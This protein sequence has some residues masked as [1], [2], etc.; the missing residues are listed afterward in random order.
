MSRWAARFRR[1]RDRCFRAGESLARVMVAPSGKIPPDQ[2]TTALL[3][4]IYL[5]LM[6]L[7]TFIRAL[8]L[9]STGS[10]VWLPLLVASLAFFFAYGISRTRHY[11]AAFA[12]AT[13]VPLAPPFAF[14]LSRQPMIDPAT[15]L[16][17]LSIPLIMATLL[18]KM[19][20]TAIVGV[21]YLVFIIWLIASDLIGVNA[22]VTAISF[23]FIITFFATVISII[24]RSSQKRLERQLAELRQAQEA[25][26]LSE[27]KFA[28]AFR[29]S[30]NA[31]VISRIED[32]TIIEANDTFSRLTGYRRDEVIGKKSSELGLWV[33]PEKRAEIVRLMKEQGSVHQRECLIRMK[34]GEVRVWLFSAEIINIEGE[35]CMLSVT[36]DITERK[37]ME[38]DLR[39]SDTALRSI[40]E[41]VFAM[42][43]NF[44]I[45]RWNPICEAMFGIKAE[46]AIGKFVGDVITMVED[47]PGQNEERMQRLISQ[48]YNHEEQVY[49]TP[50]G[51][52]WVDVHAQAIQDDGKRYGWVT[53]VSDITQQKKAQEALRR[54]EEKYRQLINASF[55]AIISTDASMRI[56]VW[57]QGATRIFGYSEHEILGRSILKLVPEE[58]RER[59]R[60]SYAMFEKQREASGAPK[61][62]FEVTGLR[63]DGT[64]VPLEISV[65]AREVDSSVIVT[66]ILRDITERKEAEERMR[67][68][69]RMKAEFLSNVSHE[70]RTPLQSISGFTKLLLNGQVPDAATQKEFLQIIDE[71]TDHLGNLINSLLDLSRLESGRFQINKRPVPIRN[72]ITSAIK[73]FHS[74]AHDKNITIVEDIPED[75]PEMEVDDGRIRQVMMNLISNAIKYS[76]PGGS[77]TIR[78]RKLEN[79][80]LV[81]V[82]DQGI[83]IP[84]QAMEHLFERFYRVENQ[85]SQA[86]SG[87][88]LGLYI[89]K[90]II[91]AHGGRI[92]VES[93]VNKGSTFSFTLPM[94]GKRGESDGKE[95]TDHR[96]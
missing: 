75:L 76:D 87:T 23:L 3:L 52:I 32:G 45:T 70:L 93:K 49:R 29:H 40:H 83:G 7:V 77:V 72:T 84:P 33:N 54:S 1:W 85:Q 13:L 57:N 80:L 96:G 39:F 88:G 28:K 67:Q 26:R 6:G 17:W 8:A 27:D 94:N 10:N 82:I 30:P 86:R 60:A 63:K 73:S 65:S 9:R 41:G 59:M 92:W 12:I 81:Q 78:V 62:V 91:D 15:E 79:D 31:F 68:I 71:E 4:A 56:L 66:A 35:P 21:L 90:Q 43:N 61:G 58:D 20:Q 2:Q 19:W 42:D 38:E 36:T 69:E 74:L 51:N 24:R 48:G 95:N 89:T 50:Y 18:M 16:M 22:A 47:Y 34:S 46:D 55:D 44:V 53:L 25:L 11:R 5:L 14:C 37:K 64:R